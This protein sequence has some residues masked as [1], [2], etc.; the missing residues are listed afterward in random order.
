MRTVISPSSGR[1]YPLTMVCAVCRVP[2]STVYLAIAPALVAPVVMAKRGPKTSVSDIE[3]VEAIRA[4]LAAT[5][6]HGEG[7]R[8]VRARLAHRGLAVGGKRVLRDAGPSL[9][10]A[11]TPGTAERR[12]CPRRHHHDHAAG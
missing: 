10:G 4:V 9:A 11:A 12:P 6:F 2:R 8:K 5:P 3:I 1:R 7:Y